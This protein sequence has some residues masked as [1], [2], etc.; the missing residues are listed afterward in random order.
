MRLTGGQYLSRRIDADRERGE[1]AASTARSQS[2]ATTSAA[3]CGA[4]RSGLVVDRPLPRSTRAD[5]V[6]DRDHRVAEAVELGEVLRLGRLDHQRARDRERHRRR[7]EAV[8]D[9]ALG[10]VVDGD[11]GGL[12]DRAQVED[13]LVRDEPVGPAVEHRVV[14]RAAGARGSWR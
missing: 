11:A 8:V 1:L 2:S 13:A 5:L 6:A 3:G 10:D 12:R 14:R 9:E 4:W 7:V